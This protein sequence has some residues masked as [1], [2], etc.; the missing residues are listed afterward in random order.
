MSGCSI[1]TNV[2][3]GYKTVFP[4]Y[5]FVINHAGAQTK[6]VGGNKHLFR[7]DSNSHGMN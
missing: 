4:R 1:S 6:Y 7:Q 3:L 2:E 5:G